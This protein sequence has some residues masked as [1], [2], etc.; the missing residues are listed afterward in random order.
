LSVAPSREPSLQ[1]AA[2]PGSRYEQYLTRFMKDLDISVE[3]K[4]RSLFPFRSLKKRFVIACS[5]RTG[6]HLLCEGL[7][8]HGAGVQEFFEIARIH[9]TCLHRGILSLDAYCEFIVR[10]FSIDGVFGVKGP[11]QIMAPLA[12][13]GE[14][15][16]FVTDWGFVYLKRSDVIKQAISELIAVLT[17]SFKSSTEP[18]RVLTDED[19]DGA[20]IAATADRKIAMNAAWEEM[21][22][23]FGIEPLRITY[24]ELAADPQAVTARTADYLELTGPPVTDKRFMAPPLQV[25]ATA[26]NVR[27]EE[28]FYHEGWCFGEE[29]SAK[30]SLGLAATPDP[31]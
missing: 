18:S 23:F 1:R 4:S 26:L 8:D 24:E 17:G 12:L 21:F 16:G 30:S 19:F 29:L 13:M 3:T 20:R 7:R 14:I 25:Q 31:S 10:R 11:L 2:A 28:R 27:W 22:E 15:P 9:K 5:P 6:S